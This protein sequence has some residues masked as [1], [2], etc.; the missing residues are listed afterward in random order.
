LGG[1][2][3]TGGLLKAAASTEMR[4]RFKPEA[5]CGAIVPIG[6]PLTRLIEEFRATA[7]V[8]DILSRGYFA[9]LTKGIENEHPERQKVARGQRLVA[10][11]QFSLTSW[12]YWFHW[13][14]S[15]WTS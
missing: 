1:A 5:F 6:Q 12:Y 3:V 14:C 7:G 8:L 13:F 11:W 15:Y 9:A 10:R 4:S 2:S